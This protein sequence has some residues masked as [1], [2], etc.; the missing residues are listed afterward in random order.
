MYN[1]GKVNVK[2]YRGAKQIGGVCTE[3]STDNTRLLFDV[4]A[5]LEGEGDQALLDIEGVTTGNLNCDGIFLTHYHGDH[6]GEIDFVDA[7]IPVYMEK[8][9]KRILEA[10]QE[11]K[12]IIGEAVWADTVIEIEVGVPVQIK[13]FTITAL[14]SD[15]SATNSVMYLIEANGKRILLTG[16][17]RLHG[18]YK[19]KVENTLKNIGHID[20]MITEG[21]NLTRANTSDSRKY[22]EDWVESVFKNALKKY[23]YV[24]LLVSSSQLDRIA[25]FS[26]CVPEGKYM[27][28]DRYQH[29]L[30]QIYDSER[31][32]RLKSNKVLYI[33]DYVMGK[34]ENA[35]FGMAIRGNY[36]FPLIV[37]DYFEKHRDDTCLIYSMWSGYIDKY[38]EVKKLVEY[39]GENVFTA[40]VSGHATKEDMED[41]IKMISPDKLIV[42][43]TNDVD[44]LLNLPS[45]I[46]LVQI[47]DCASTLL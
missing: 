36:Y 30:I 39:A 18:F 17:Y 44:N 45:R 33:G 4:G 28:V 8:Y 27:L 31:D 9:A 5:P 43:H 22:D 11:H 25:S 16:D 6:I 19:D 3:I 26:R 15:H 29:D 7:K 42:H 32:E 24:F 47:I 35:G 34:A 40:H 20:L 41:V 38:S 1:S 13:D 12:K 2:L 37:K 23:K 21:T 46:E 14:A 10:Q